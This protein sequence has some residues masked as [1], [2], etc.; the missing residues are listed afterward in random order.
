M[1][2]FGSTKSKMVKYKNDKNLSYAEVTEVVFVLY[3]QELTTISNKIQ[4]PCI[5]LFLIN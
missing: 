1:K 5:H 2:L 3:N 4:K